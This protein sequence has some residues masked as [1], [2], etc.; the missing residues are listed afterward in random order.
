MRTPKGWTGPKIVDGLQEEGSFRSHQV[1]ITDVR[2]NHEHLVLLEQW[3]HS[4]EP[5]KLFDKS[6]A[7]VAELLDRGEVDTLFRIIRELVA[8][9]VAVVPDGSRAMC[10]SETL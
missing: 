9:G 7:L 3:L 5:E 8:H 10:S 1:P 4:Y 2:A 6:G